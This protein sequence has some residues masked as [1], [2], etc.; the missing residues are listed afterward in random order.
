[1]NGLISQRAQNL[2]I[3]FV[4]KICKLQPAEKF[5]EDVTKAEAEVSKTYLR[6]K[7]LSALKKH[8]L[9]G[10]WLAQPKLFELLGAKDKNDFGAK[11]CSLIPERNG[12]GFLS[13][14]QVN[15]IQK[16]GIPEFKDKI[17]GNPRLNLQYLAENSLGKSVDC[18]DK[19]LQE[20]PIPVIKDE[21]LIREGINQLKKY[22]PSFDHI[23][24]DSRK[25]GF[26]EWM[27]E[28]VNNA[29]DEL[30]STTINYEKTP[31]DFGTI[32]EVAD[33]N[34]LLE[35]SGVVNAFNEDALQTVFNWMDTNFKLAAGE[36]TQALEEYRNK[37]LACFPQEVAGRLRASLGK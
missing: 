9:L 2:L 37:A 21:N 4:Q 28:F 5:T 30:F 26:S 17:I 16:Y 33:A 12:Y 25:E 20:E 1:M 6:E 13:E 35:A 10:Y 3:A 34:D 11:I 31:K 27:Y 19:A 7:A 32:A 18:F 23:I 29:Q 36:N 24:E 8:V 15:I 22:A 14:D